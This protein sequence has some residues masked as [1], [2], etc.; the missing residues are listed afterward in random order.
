MAPLKLCADLET[1]SSKVTAAQARSVPLRI[2]F[3]FCHGCLLH[4]MVL[5]VELCHRWGCVALGRL[6]VVGAKEAV[7]P[8]FIQILQVAQLVGKRV[9]VTVDL[10]L[11]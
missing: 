11:L 8:S 10:A 6:G 3:P 9:L 1:A 4:R 2:R 7:D 5:S